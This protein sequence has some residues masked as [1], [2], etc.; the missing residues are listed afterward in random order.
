LIC[1]L[2]PKEHSG[3]PR[4]LNSGPTTKPHNCGT[5]PATQSYW[6]S[7]CVELRAKDQIKGCEHRANTVRTPCSHTRYGYTICA[8]QSSAPK[9]K[10]SS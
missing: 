5:L 8:S 4:A 7:L 10:R 3:S 6:R 1:H 9:T 2:L